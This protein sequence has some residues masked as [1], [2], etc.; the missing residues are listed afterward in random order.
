MAGEVFPLAGTIMLCLLLESQLARRSFPWGFGIRNE[1]SEGDDSGPTEEGECE[2]E[3]DWVVEAG[4]GVSG[5]S[6]L[7]ED[8]GPCKMLGCSLVGVICS[9]IYNV[10]YTIGLQG[11]KASEARKS[12]EN[13]EREEDVWRGDS[14]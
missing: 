2:P 1:N 12:E 14:E 3:A 6:R 8:W 13:E 9:A 7:L 11:D 4:A 10:Q 5:N